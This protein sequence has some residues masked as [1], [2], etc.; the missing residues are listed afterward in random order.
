MKFNCSRTDLANAVT[1]VSRAVSSKTTIPALEG[2]LMRAKDG[3]IIL[4]AYDLE[5]GI[6]TK[7]EASVLTPG[8][9][10]VSAKLFSE[11]VRKLPEEVVTIETD[12]RL[13]TYI[14]SGQ[15][16]YQIVGISS[17]EFPDLPT[18]ET[19]DELIIKESLIKNMIKQTLYAV[20]ENN[21]KPIYTGSL[22]E[23]KDR[24]LKIVAVDGF[25]MAIRTEAIDYD[26]DTRFVI[27]GKTQ[28]EFLKL[29]GNDEEENVSLIVG[30]RH[31]MFKVKEYSIISRLIEGTFLDYETTIPKTEET[32]VS[33][34]T[35]V[36]INS[37]ERMA[38]ITSE[39]IQSPVKFTL[40]GDEIRLSCST[41][42]GKAADV[43]R[44]NIAG[45]DVTIG[46]NHKYLLDA[47]KNAETDEVKL[48]INGGLS[49]MIVKPVSGDSFLFLVVPMRLA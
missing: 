35:R 23:I 32:V 9:I 2:I 5:I 31:V 3:K 40:T 27:P 44:T 17:V 36:L 24:I 34:N 11:I 37:V 48:I 20:S 15:A 47:L 12:E 49:P 41:A 29:L 43:L 7:I 4:S 33:I 46:F 42:V 19:T 6:T 18:F 45:N 1:N 30:E 10:V 8:E 16:D 14:T 38:L 28:S 39:K 26:R 22:F 25:R 13:I 21:A